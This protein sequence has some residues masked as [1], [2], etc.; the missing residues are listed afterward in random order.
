MSELYS[1]LH[2]EVE[3]RLEEAERVGYGFDLPE[4]VVAPNAPKIS[5]A[6]SEVT[7]AT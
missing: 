3:L 1:R 7:I 2:E 6:Q 4:V 5:G